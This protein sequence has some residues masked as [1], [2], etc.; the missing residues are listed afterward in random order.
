MLQPA[1]T[2]C[3][4]PPASCVYGLP[5][6][7]CRLPDKYPPGWQQVPCCPS[8]N[9]RNKASDQYIPGYRNDAVPDADADRPMLLRFR[10]GQSR[11]PSSPENVPARETDYRQKSRWHTDSHAHSVPPRARMPRR[12]RRRTSARWDA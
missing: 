4:Q 6:L 7:L 5:P 1:A 12:A 2:D 11:L 9:G 8:A 3:P 10:S